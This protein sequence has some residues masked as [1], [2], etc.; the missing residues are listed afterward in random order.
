MKKFRRLQAK[1]DTPVLIKLVTRGCL[2]VVRWA[3]E[4]EQNSLGMKAM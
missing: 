3:D 4:L 1:V 2:N